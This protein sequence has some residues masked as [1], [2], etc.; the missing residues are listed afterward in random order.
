MSD[1]KR[2]I[3]YLYRYEDS[4]NGDNVGFV[5][6]EAKASELKL[7]VNIKSHEINECELRIGMY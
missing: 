5:K 7:S 3:S 2:Y 6:L 4:V 1:Y